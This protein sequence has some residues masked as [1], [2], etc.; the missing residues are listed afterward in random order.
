MYIVNLH[1]KNIPIAPPSEGNGNIFKRL[2]AP[3]PVASRNHSPVAR[4]LARGMERY[5]M[6]IR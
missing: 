6:Q 4:A 5:S 3:G 1:G 2:M